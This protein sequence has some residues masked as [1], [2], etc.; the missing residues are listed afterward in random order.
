MSWPMIGAAG[1]GIIALLAAIVL[2]VT[3]RKKS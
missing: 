3:G 2:A 1:V